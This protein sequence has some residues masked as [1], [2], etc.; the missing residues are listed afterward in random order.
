MNNGC[1]QSYGWVEQ[2]WVYLIDIQIIL[3]LNYRDKPKKTWKVLVLHTDRQ[4]A[5]CGDTQSIMGNKRDQQVAYIEEWTIKNSVHTLFNI[6][7][8]LKRINMLNANSYGH[9]NVFTAEIN[10]HDDKPKGHSW[11]TI[12]IQCSMFI[13]INQSEQASWSASI[14]NTS[15]P[16][17]QSVLITSYKWSQNDVS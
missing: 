13:E 16:C 4:M 9:L 14:T 15:F 8:C 5:N 7:M 6:K 2:V 17:S 3:D 1:T 11:L 12:E 10:G